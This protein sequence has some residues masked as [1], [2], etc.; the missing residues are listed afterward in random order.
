MD[1]D[2][3]I[4]I[5]DPG[6]FYKD[7]FNKNNSL[8]YLTNK[9]DIKYNKSIN[10]TEEHNEFFNRLLNDLDKETKEQ[11]KLKNQLAFILF[12][13]KDG[14]F[15]ENKEV[16]KK[17]DL[18]EE[19]TEDKIFEQLLEIYSKDDCCYSE[20][21]IFSTNSPCLAR[22]N[23]VPCMIQAFVLAKL[24][25]KKHGI[26][27]IIGYLKPWGFSGSYDKQLPECPI[28]DCIST[29]P[30]EFKP[31]ESNDIINNSPQTMTTD[32]TDTEL[33]IPV[34]KQ[35]IQEI[36]NLVFSMKDTIST[37]TKNPKPKLDLA[38]F[39]LKISKTEIR[40]NFI[41]KLNKIVSYLF[42]TED[43]NKSFAAFRQCGL[44]RFE[45]C[46]TKI[47]KLLN[48]INSANTCEEIR[49]YLKNNF[50]PWWNKKVEDAFS[51]FLK[52]KTS[53]LLQEHAVCLFLRDIPETE[54]FFNIGY[55]ISGE[56]DYLV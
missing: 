4:K 36:E 12:R 8:K 25:Y 5:T 18:L 14:S 46:K 44:E 55:V 29:F 56:F 10:L 49:E 43:S 11:L 52:N 42:L 39:C 21:Y 45:Q 37:K 51:K 22:K 20:I 3:I 34:Y 32:K 15:E 48:E 47:D 28:K 33:L 30:K 2:F 6:I 17:S 40:E 7:Y 54:P 50:F 24:L 35:I 26:K 9:S 53:W 19:H 38:Q 1:E 41:K 31:L 16:Y 27:T 23:H 13:K